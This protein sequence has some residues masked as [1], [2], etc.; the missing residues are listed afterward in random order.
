MESS[1]LLS[2]TNQFGQ[3]VGLPL[4]W[5]PVSAPQQH[6]LQGKHVQLV[7]LNVRQHGSDLYQAFCATPNP[8][9]LWT[10]MPYGPFNDIEAFQSWLESLQKLPGAYFYVLQNPGRQALGQFALTAIDTNN[11]AVEL[12]HVLF[13]PALQHTTA[14]T[15]AVYLILEH[16]FRLGYRRCCWKCNALNAAS[17]RAARRF[18][19]RYE[20][21]F[22]NA[23]VV[24][25][26]N[27]D[28]AWFAITG[29][30]WPALQQAYQAW[31]TPENFDSNGVQKQSLSSL[32][33]N[34]C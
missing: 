3:P 19:F 20:G 32:T 21:L 4:T 7:A 2:V 30:D 10:Y 24:K 14:A 25:G 15:E 27:R 23:M 17:Q 34:L 9:M 28:T 18:G 22:R 13:G 12:A 26:R 29:E 16:V 33:G 11:G 31:L 8:G 1:E 6:P 5:Q